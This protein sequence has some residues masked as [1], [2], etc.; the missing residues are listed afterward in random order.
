MSERQ[1]WWRRARRCRSVVKSDSGD[2]LG[3]RLS[4]GVT[5][6]DSQ[7]VYRSLTSSVHSADRPSA[8]SEQLLTRL[9]LEERFTTDPEVVL[10]ALRG[11]G[12]G[13]SREHLFVL[14]ELG[15]LL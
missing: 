2:W 4:V 14:S 8:Y 5:Q 15:M 12:K 6:V 10:A 13:L 3:S 9:G 11:P 7:S 1:G